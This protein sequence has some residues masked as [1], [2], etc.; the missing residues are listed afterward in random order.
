[1]T[2][3]ILTALKSKQ[4]K[5]MTYILQLFATIWYHYYAYMGGNCSH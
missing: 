2:D 5:P 1:M 4:M 3:T